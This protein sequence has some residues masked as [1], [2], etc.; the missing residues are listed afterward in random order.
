MNVNNFPF[1]TSRTQPPSSTGWSPYPLT[2]QLEGN[3]YWQ[4]ADLEGGAGDTR[5]TWTRA[6]LPKQSLTR[7]DGAVSGVVV[8][9]VKVFAAL[10]TEVKRTWNVEEEAECE[11]LR[12][13]G[14]GHRRRNDAYL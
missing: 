3:I 2:P 11:A 6:G 9:S 10:W 1:G 4:R 5:D 14:P 13:P 7:R 12:R 8:K